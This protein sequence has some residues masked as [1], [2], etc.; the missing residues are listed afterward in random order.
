MSNSLDRIIS[1]VDSDISNDNIK[2]VMTFMIIL[3]ILALVFFLVENDIVTTKFVLFMIVIT[4][5]IYTY[6]NRTYKN[7]INDLK[8]QVDMN[9][10]S[11]ILTN[12][13]NAESDN[14]ICKEFLNKKNDYSK[15]L[16]GIVK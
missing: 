11:D 8:K 10:L 13:C 4:I 14:E 1:F 5:F 9:S 6:N 16:R 2:L 12:M 15:S 7:R 3:C